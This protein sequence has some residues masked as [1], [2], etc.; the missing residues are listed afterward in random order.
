MWVHL[1]SVFAILLCSS[2]LGE[3]LPSQY[4]R[5]L[6]VE[7]DAIVVA[8][9]VSG[10][11]LS[12][13]KAGDFEHETSFEA[14]EVLKGD[15][16]LASAPLR[17]RDRSLFALKSHWLKDET[18][19]LKRAMLFLTRT[20]AG[21]W[22]LDYLYGLTTDDVVVRPTQVSNPGPYVLAEKPELSWGDAKQIVRQFLPQIEALKALKTISDPSRRNQ[23]LFDWIKAR[24]GEFYGLFLK[25]GDRT[26]EPRTGWGRLEH[27]VF[28]WILGASIHA[29]SWL[30]L[31]R[32]AETRSYPVTS[33]N[34]L[35]DSGT[36]T[37]HSGRAFLLAK[38][39]DP[40]QSL[41]ARRT[42]VSLLSSALNNGPLN[43][44][45]PERNSVTPADQTSILQAA[46]PFTTHDDPILRREAIY[47]LLSA[48]DPFNDAS[49]PQKNKLALPVIIK[50]LSAEQ[51]N[52]M[53]S[54]IP[55]RLNHLM[56]E[57]EWK[58]LTGNDSRI[59]VTVSA[60]VDAG[61]LHLQVNSEHL[62]EGAELPVEVV[63]ERLDDKGITVEVVT[64]ML[65]AH[66]PKKWP[67]D[68]EGCL[69]LEPVS[70]EALPSGAWKAHL[71]GI[72]ADSRKLPW[73]SW[74]TCFRIP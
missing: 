72:T 65:S 44:V 16:K 50:A 70:V 69:S 45:S 20:K 1:F 26:N 39:I 7:S 62:P 11:S 32:H 27:D 71:K 15:S 6:A 31:Q 64:K 63:L 10:S 18:I 40:E 35:E 41:I 12:D 60:N 8:R 4:L 25:P 53:L 37:N 57:A 21:A 38:L 24:K 28:E 30:A 3:N 73:S 43:A 9:P 56:D 23:S 5:A 34:N 66:Y 74:H 46:M 2:V 13:H 51:D 42:A 22:N 59:C 58:A 33:W 61:K 68:W 49:R 19:E 54:D 17:V 29:D 47:L 48:T 52:S 67:K 55:R 36:F 14:E